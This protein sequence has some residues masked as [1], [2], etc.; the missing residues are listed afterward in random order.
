VDGYSVKSDFADHHGNLHA[1]KLA[2]GQYYLA[3][4]NTLAVW[5]DQQARDMKLLAQKNPALA[6]RPVTKRMGRFTGYAVSK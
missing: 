5:Q 3:P 6:K 1:V 2:P 4:W